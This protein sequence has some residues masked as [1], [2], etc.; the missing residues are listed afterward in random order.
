MDRDYFAD[1]LAEALGFE[2]GVVEAEHK[3]I[4]D[5]QLEFGMKR[6]LQDIHDQ[7]E[8]HV[9][10]LQRALDAV[11]RTGEAESKMKRGKKICEQIIEMAGDEPIEL[12]K[13]TILAKYRS[14]DTSEM[15]YELCDE[16]G[17][18]E[19][20]D[21]FENALEDDEDHIDYLREQAMIMTRERVTGQSAVE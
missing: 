4:N 5:G 1:Q 21:V 20:C 13:S 3:L 7:D 6:Q 19:V 8:Q 14:S 11:G 15:F 17:A 9:R 2:E 12:L 10:N 16:V 18:S